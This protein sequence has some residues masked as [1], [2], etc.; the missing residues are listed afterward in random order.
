MNRLY[1]HRRWIMA[2]L[3]VVL[4]LAALPHLRGLT[5]SSILSY[6][7]A[8]PFLAALVL[9]GIYCIKSVFMVIPIIVLYISAGILFPPVWAVL[10]TYLCLFCELAIGYWIG[11]RMGSDKV[12]EIMERNPRAGKFLSFQQKNDSTACFMARVTPLPFDLVSMFFGASGMGVGRYLVFSMLGLSP[13]M[14]PWVI[15]GNAITN[16]LSPEFLIP[17]GISIVITAVV[18]A[19][20]RR[21][22]KRIQSA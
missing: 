10:I 5:V 7:P 20:F 3:L 11:K 1:N 9:I 6:T 16:P 12:N 4:I 17:F 14:I 15:A 18:F 19:A 2:I 13:G 21:I 22:Q 8:S